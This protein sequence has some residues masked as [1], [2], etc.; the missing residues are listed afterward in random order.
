M[1]ARKTGPPINSQPC[2]CTRV[3]IKSGNL[4]CEFHAV[5][6][7]IIAMLI[8]FPLERIVKGRNSAKKTLCLSVEK[9]MSKSIEHP[10]RH[11]AQV[12]WKRYFLGWWLYVSKAK[13]GSLFLLHLGQDNLVII[14][15][16]IRQSGWTIGESHFQFNF[17]HQ[18][19]KLWS[20]TSDEIENWKITCD[21]K[22][23][24]IEIFCLRNAS[25]IL[26][27]PLTW[28]NNFI[29]K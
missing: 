18:K 2:L 20:I 19:F 28:N 27:A 1:L 8:L 29:L 21:F 10:T 5:V 14:I 9:T 13:T 26:F 17:R 12:I 24:W 11:H 15:I 7:S 22:P 6:R 4:L 25:E 3:K 23:T 16:P